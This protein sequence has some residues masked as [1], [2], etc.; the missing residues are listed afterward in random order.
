MRLC[1]KDIIHQLKSGRISISPYPKVERISGVTVDFHLGNEVRIF[2]KKKIFPYI[3]LSQLSKKISNNSLED[4]I[5]RRVLLKDC[6]NILLNPSEIILAITYEHL[7]LPSN[8][9]GWIDGKSSFAR[10]GLMIHVSS[11]RI[12]PGWSGKIVLEI[13]NLGK[14]PLL[15]KPN[16]VIC[17]ISFEEISQS[18]LRPYNSKKESKYHN[19]FHPSISFISG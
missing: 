12:D 11:N 6:E 18:S 3:D 16:M 10:L 13:V 14:F 1:D 17:E 7:S 8:V 19:Q 9:V 15:L 5:S 2:R 4:M